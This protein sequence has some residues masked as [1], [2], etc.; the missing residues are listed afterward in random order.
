MEVKRRMKA[1]FAP[2]LWLV[3]TL[4]AVVPVQAQTSRLTMQGPAENADAAPIRDSLGRLCLDVEAAGRKQTVNPQMVDHV[5]SLKNNCA[6]SLRLK[7]CYL[8]SD[9]CNDVDLQPFKRVDTILGSARGN[10]F[11]R[12]TI[13]QK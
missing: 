10:S 1:A 13:K 6:K 12:Y 8:N 5:V 7:V 3:G 9:H 11:F 2:A 4:T